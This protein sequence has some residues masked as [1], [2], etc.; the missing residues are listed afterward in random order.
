MVKTLKLSAREV[1][2]ENNKSFIACSAKIGDRYVKVKFTKD[3]ETQPRKRGL[4]DLT[5]DTSKCSMEKGKPYVNKKGFDAI[6]QSTIWVR[7]VVKL[8]A[9]TEEE[10]AAINEANFSGLFEAEETSTDP[11]LPF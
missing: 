2:Q 7:E 4:Y 9:Y 10:L 6:G 5:I 1:K 11:E 3:C 8:R